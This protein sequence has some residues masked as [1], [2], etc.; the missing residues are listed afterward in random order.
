MNRVELTLFYP[1][2]LTGQS[3]GGGLSA[4]IAG[5]KRTHVILDGLGDPLLG[6][7]LSA[8]WAAAG[9][10]NAVDVAGQAAWLSKETTKGGT[11][12]DATQRTETSADEA[13][14]PPGWLSEQEMD[15]AAAMARTFGL[16][17]RDRV[18]ESFNAE[19]DLGRLY[20]RMEYEYRSRLA[21]ALMF[22]LPAIVLHYAAPM[23]ASGGGAHVQ[24]MFFPW[25]FE[26]LLI[27]WTCL[28]AGWP[29]LFQGGLSLVTVRG[30]GD[31]LTSLLVLAAYVPSA[32]GVL[33]MVAGVEPFF[34]AAGPAF[35]VAGVAVI[36]AVAQRWLIYRY[37]ERLRGRANLMLL[38]F[39]RLVGAWLIGGAVLWLVGGWSMA[40]AVLLLL[41]PMASMGGVNPW[42]PGWS[43][44]LPTLAFALLMVMDPVVAGYSLEGVRLEVA[45]GFAL[46]Q[47]VVLG[48]GWRRIQ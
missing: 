29:I 23:L 22:G 6:Q 8:R 1:N 34:G 7:G 2:F 42:N 43:S 21:T 11:P 13:V 26:A 36:L 15:R 31:L 39:G 44:V 41:A 35:H 17:I 3:A 16:E 47:T 12:A 38:R 32:V 25:L 46:V 48:I 18:G 24:G 9:F 45:G 37:I 20:E 19:N 5:M 14:A 28:A 4:T 30:S 40:L 33:G 27:G 10:N